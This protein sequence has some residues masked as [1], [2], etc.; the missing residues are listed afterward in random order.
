MI[1]NSLLNGIA[2]HRD[3]RL[4]IS[5]EEAFPETPEPTS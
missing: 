1:A 4:S 5:P 2:I 3:R